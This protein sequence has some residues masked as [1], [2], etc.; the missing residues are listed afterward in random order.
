MT[1]ELRATPGRLRKPTLELRDFALPFGFLALAA[2]L[3]LSPVAVVIPR[4]APARVEPS[5]LLVEPRRIAMTDPPRILVEGQLEHCNACHQIFRSAHGGGESIH[6]HAEIQ[7]AHGLNARCVNCHDANDRERLTLRDGTT[8]P[9]AEAPLLCAQC[10]GTVYRDWQ[11]G[12]H[13]KT[14]G[15]WK[16]GEPAQRRLQCNECHDPHSPRYPGYV[17]LPGP[18]TLRMGVQPALEEAAPTRSPLQHWQAA[19]QARQEN[20]TPSG[21]HP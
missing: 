4:S 8:I 15:S 10:H 13:G 21:G 17:P 18:Q 6:Y 2:L 7:L 9:Y 5:A 19:T 12:T 14:L 11:A 3:F 1:P 20:R 16:V